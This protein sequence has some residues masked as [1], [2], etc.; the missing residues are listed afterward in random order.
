MAQSIATPNPAIPAPRHFRAERKT[1]RVLAPRQRPLTKNPTGVSKA[2]CGFA[3]RQGAPIRSPAGVLSTPNLRAGVESGVPKKFRVLAP[4][5][6]AL[7]RG[8]IGAPKTLGVLGQL[9]DTPERLETRVSH[10]KQMTAY[11]SN[12]YSSHVAFARGLLLRVSV[13]FRLEGFSASHLFATHWSL[14]T[15]HWSAPPDTLNRL[16]LLVNHRKQTIAYPSTRNVPPQIF[17]SLSFLLKACRLRGLQCGRI[18][19]ARLPYGSV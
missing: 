17:P 12:R 10:R 15:S 18:V 8:P 14:A 2:P 11:T 16:E 13:G 1:L 4:R 3:P 9:I 6:G 5:Q 19:A 7:V